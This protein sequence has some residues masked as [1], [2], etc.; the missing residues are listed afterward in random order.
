MKKSNI[1]TLSQKS[2]YFLNKSDPE[3]S[4]YNIGK[5]YELNKKINYDKLSLAIEQI[6]MKYSIL[7]TSF[8]EKEG[9]I[10]QLISDYSSTV[11]LL[12]D[13]VDSEIE[14]VIQ[15]IYESP[16]KNLSVPPIR[17]IN[18]VGESRSFL[19][20]LAHHILLDGWS[21]NLLLKEIENYIVNEKI[22][23]LSAIDSEYYQ[24]SDYVLE[25]KK[26]LCSEEY[27]EDRRYWNRKLQPIE[28]TNPM[29]NSISREKLDSYSQRLEFKLNFER[30]SLI[31]SFCEKHKVSIGQFLYSIFTITVTQYN[32]NILPIM[33]LPVH[34]RQK[35]EHFEALGLFM[36]T[37]PL[38]SHFSIDDT[39]ID[40]LLKCKE[41]WNNGLIHQSFPFSEIKSL[42]SLKGKNLSQLG[43]I[44]FSVENIGKNGNTDAFKD[45]WNLKIAPKADLVINSIIKEKNIEVNIEFDPN[46]LLV[47]QVESMFKQFENNVNTMLE[48]KTC[49]YI[50]SVIYSSEQNYK[51]QTHCNEE[52]LSK[53]VDKKINQN[54]SNF[55]LSDFENS[56]NSED[57]K[58]SLR[59]IQSIFKLNN[60][61]SESTVGISIEKTFL[62]YVIVIACIK[63][64]IPFV[65]IDKKTPKILKL[66]LLNDNEINFF[67]SEDIL[68]LCEVINIKNDV[69]LYSLPNKRS[70]PD[71]CY[72]IFTSG[73]TGNPKLVRISRNSFL[74]FMHKIKERYELTD[75]EVIYSISNVA[76]DIFIEEL[77][78]WL[79]IIDSILYIS[80]EKDIHNPMNLITKTEAIG[81]SI[82]SLPTSYW[83]TLVDNTPSSVLSSWSIPKKVIIG[84]EDYNVKSL[85][86]WQTSIGS[87]GQLINTYGPTENSPV[88][89][90]MILDNIK[91]GSI[92]GKIFDNVKW[93]ILQHNRSVPRGA[94]GELYLSGTQLFDGYNTEVSKSKYYATGDLVQEV[95][96]NILAFKGRVDKQI[97]INGIRVSPEIYNSILETP[98]LRKLLSNYSIATSK[99]NL[100]YNE[101]IIYVKL[102]SQNNEY[103][104]KKEFYKL[105]RSKLPEYLGF[106]KLKF[107]SNIPLTRNG[108]VDIK[109]LKNYVIESE[110]VQITNNSSLEEKLQVVWRDILGIQEINPEENFFDIGGSSLKIFKLIETI[111]TKF[112]LNL[113][114]TDIFEFPSI[115]LMAE[116]IDDKKIDKINITQKKFRSVRRRN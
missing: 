21:L 97:K 113:T 111:N 80:K 76:F 16:F 20:I 104:F 68:E 99:L 18:L 98:S 65:I 23:N 2:F 55:L 47:F 27:R 42:E 14:K 93:K 11:E 66:E 34:N 40:I 108:K 19:I 81:A 17:F 25:E 61:N 70:Y 90:L 54:S 48:N 77:A 116:F 51:E 86:K 41:T 37:I 74:S 9:E 35:I 39:F 94:I 31:K 10:Y 79:S 112:N 58:N 83:H 15:S 3:S 59:K 101:I 56:K 49:K 92:I 43:R 114:I 89:S 62:L 45:Y 32:N 50:D 26:Y 82:V 95:D 109:K 73:T 75:R 64:K 60:I 53:L 29:F 107:V 69:K 6:S 105:C 103:N 72:G 52:E 110:K 96:D 36:N 100:D 78:I 1:A 22:E 84:G 106:V 71:F 46:I 28:L 5:V 115:K 33:I 85:I 30:H 38:Y 91:V 57:L 102:Q 7:R 88:S 12:T 8:I 4:S 67:I 44:I 63:N 87:R 13:I 24:F